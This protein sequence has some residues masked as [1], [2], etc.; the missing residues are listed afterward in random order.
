MFWNFFLGISDYK[1]SSLN[2]IKFS[3]LQV[4]LLDHTHL[5]MDMEQE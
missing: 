4:Y 5:S 1:N 2:V 3:L